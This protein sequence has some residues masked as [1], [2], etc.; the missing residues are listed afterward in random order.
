MN[1]H[2][3]SINQITCRMKKKEMT[4]EQAAARLEELATQVE[5]GETGIDELAAALKEARELITFCRSKLYAADEE[6]QKI[7]ASIE[8]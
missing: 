3:D 6:V 2:L 5:S 1:E 7:V 4:Y 8:K